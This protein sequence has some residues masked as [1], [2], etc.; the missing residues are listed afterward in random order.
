MVLTQ[1]EIEKRIADSYELPNKVLQAV[2]EPVVSV[3]TS[4]YQHAAY[5]RDCIEGVLAQK[6]DFPIEF[7]IGEDFSTDG[8]RE[9]V[10]E[11]AGKYPELIR[12]LTADY[13]VGS[14]A[15]GRRCQRVLRGKYVAIC[16]GDDYWI[17]PLKLQKQVNLLE[18]HPE[19][20]MCFHNF[21]SLEHGKLTLGK[22]YPVS[23]IDAETFARAEIN[24]QSLTVLHKNL[25]PIIP[26]S[27]M[28]QSTGTHFKFLVWAD[29]GDILYVNEA[30]AV[31]RRHPGGVWSSK[32]KFE[33][34]KMELQNKSTMISY[35][36]S[37]KKILKILRHT[38]VRKSIDYSFYHLA[39]FRFR[40]TFYFILKSF[41]YGLST[42]HFYHWSWLFAKQ[43][44][45]KS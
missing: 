25:K 27:L 35:F 23:R 6:T 38:Y 39:Q 9:I 43:M 10:F 44:K 37:R 8:T 28:N 15:N 14:K 24:I 41:K 19:C 30:M 45:I 13:N 36:R 4:T 40:E 21:Y 12:V 1:Q 26:E 17:D 20:S 22:S 42:I 31:Y 34:G 5:I 29:Q 16:E 11:Y 3:R 2:P 18:A 33:Q 32:S 7:I